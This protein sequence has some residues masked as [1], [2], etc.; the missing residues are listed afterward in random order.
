MLSVN[1]PVYNINA[2]PLVLQLSEQAKKLDCPVEIRV[3]DDGS[4]ERIKKIN[5]ELSKIPQVVYVEMN[6]NFGRAGIRNKMGH[7]SGYKYLLFIDADSEIISEKYLENYLGNV[8]NAD[9]LCG[10]TA[11]QPNPPED[12]E[13]LLRWLYGTKREAIL[14]SQRNEK[15]GFI[16]TSNNFLIKK[17]LFS[18]VHFRENIGRYG[19]EDTLLGYDLFRKGVLPLHIQNPVEHTGLED[20]HTFLTKTKTALKNLNFITNE[21]LNEAPEFIQQVQFLSKYKRIT[22]LIPAVVFRF[23]YTTFHRAME[24]NLTGKKT[25][26]FWFDLYK[27]CFYSTIKNRET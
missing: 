7:D 4:E 27:L 25:R 26:L 11:Y 2:R 10:G 5:R 17:Q 3:Y 18:E 23:F 8:Q 1:I 16:I 22:K 24:K 6:E 14:A 13:K 9:V 12:Q 21:I 20:A 19:H 15:K